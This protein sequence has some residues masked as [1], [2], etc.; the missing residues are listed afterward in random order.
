MFIDLYNKI[1][2][3]TLLKVMVTLY[4]KLLCMTHY[5]SSF[6]ALIMPCNAP[7]NALYNLINNCNH[8]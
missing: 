8:S 4:L 5:K 6:N 1:N 2:L 7:Y 3:I